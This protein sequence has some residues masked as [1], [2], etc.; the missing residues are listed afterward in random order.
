VLIDNT[1]ASWSGLLYLALFLCSKF[2][3]SIPFIP[4]RRETD[5]PD[6]PI[7]PSHEDLRAVPTMSSFPTRNRAAAPPI[8]LLILPSIPITVASYITSTR[9]FN[10]YH[11]GSDIFAGMAIGV[12]SAWFS[13]RWY[14]MPIS[15]GAGWS[16]GARSRDRAWGIG[17]GY[18]GYVGLEGWATEDLSEMQVTDSAMHQTTIGSGHDRREGGIPNTGEDGSMD[19]QPGDRQSKEENFV[20]PPDG[21]RWANLARR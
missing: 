15:R 9:Y 5:S 21:S 19:A 10:Y 13:F 4:T 14:H 3:I 2:A 7:L 8:Y 12:L 18:G 6:D 20:L 11:F 16:W 1:K 17:V